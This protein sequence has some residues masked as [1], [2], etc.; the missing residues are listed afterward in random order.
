MPKPKN[1][2]S[3]WIN[4]ALAG[5][6]GLRPLFQDRM[7]NAPDRLFLRDAGVGD[8]VEMA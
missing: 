5:P 4:M 8:A 6:I 1:Q 3:T 2:R 7:L